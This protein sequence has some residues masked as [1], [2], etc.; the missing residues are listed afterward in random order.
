MEWIKLTMS[1]ANSPNPPASPSHFIRVEAEALNR[2]A[3]RLDGDMR[4]AM[5]YA[6]ALISN[7]AAS[8]HRVA[9]T[10]IGKSGII[11]RKIAATLS[12]TGTSACFLHPAEALH[13]DLGMLVRGDLIVALSYSGETE[14]LLR[15]LPEFT[16]L[17]LPL[18]SLTGCLTS[19]LARAS[20]VALDVSVSEEA[21]SLNLAPTA[22]TTV[23]LALGD[24][25]ALELSRRSGFAPHDFADLHPGGRLG[26]RLTR[27]RDLMHSGEALPRVTPTTL[28]PQVIHEM[29]HKKLGMTTV[30]T[31]TGELAGIVSDG[32]LRRL[33]ERVGPQS[34]ER[35]A[36]DIMNSSP[37][38][39][40]PTAF[41][42]EA[43]AQME[44]RKIT[45]LVVVE[46]GRV[47]GVVHLHD[48]WELAPR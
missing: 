23:M 35:S 45:S 7:A 5:D 36:G 21:C 8:G 6:L 40:A 20:A 34:L 18:I 17:G 3:N 24:A 14:E 25:I 33:L 9:V 28:M 10:G 47:H 39:I 41:A 46:D 44:E 16:R 2:L 26:R 1:E 38:M 15:L 31:A 48:L 42:T 19:S 32:D 37:Q 29:S 43:L 4:P 11:A 30:L 13:G 27:V 22:S 12:S